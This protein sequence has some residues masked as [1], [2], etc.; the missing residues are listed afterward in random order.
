MDFL[1]LA[2][3]GVIAANVPMGLVIEIIKIVSFGCLGIVAIGFL[4]NC[5]CD[6]FECR[7]WRHVQGR[8]DARR[9]MS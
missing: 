8:A 5:L 6:L 1:G 2:D 9:L 3:P 4:L 7:K